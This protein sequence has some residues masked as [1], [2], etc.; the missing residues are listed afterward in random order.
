[1]KKKRT[2]MTKNAV[3]YNVAKYFIRDVTSIHTGCFVQYFDICNNNNMNIVSV[4]FGCVID[5]WTHWKLS[6][7]FFS[8]LL[9]QYD[10]RRPKLSITLLV[11]GS[12]FKKKSKGENGMLNGR[13]FLEDV[14]VVP[15]YL[16]HEQTPDEKGMKQTTDSSSTYFIHTHH[17]VT[18]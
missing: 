16:R 6:V 7:F 8:F 12:T 2:P 1:M 11:N 13:L 18:G 9:N 4:I 17:D 14:P 15:N 3:W 10:R 5:H